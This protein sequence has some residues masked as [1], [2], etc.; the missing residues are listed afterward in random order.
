MTRSL[1][2][3]LALAALS[4][5]AARATSCSPVCECP[6]FVQGQGARD[7]I[8]F[9]V[10]GASDV[11]SN[12]RPFVALPGLDSAQI[13]LVETASG[14]PVPFTIEPSPW[15]ASHVWIV[16]DAMLSGGLEY[17]LTAGSGEGEVS[18][19]AVSSYADDRAPDLV[20]L[21][22]SSREPCNEVIFAD[23]SAYASDS[24]RPVLFHFIV[25]GPGLS[26]PAHFFRTSTGVF[27]GESG[28]LLGRSLDAEGCIEDTLPE[29]E[30]GAEYDVRLEAYDLA[31]QLGT[32]TPSLRITTQHKGV[33]P[34]AD[35]T[36][37]AGCCVL[38][39]GGRASY[40]LAPLA[41]LGIVAV[42]WRR[43][44]RRAAA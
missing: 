31:G 42:W 39:V 21:N 11:P 14:T 34:D 10:D 30:A 18:T 12:V 22:Q 6:L 33:S 27:S 32:E 2:L 29:A 44:R 26:S 17:T 43:R 24:A 7:S 9:P 3:L 37:V 19:F 38:S 28:L 8:L 5:S 13:T 20:Q 23:L 40:R 25:D 16:P 41:A 36:C 1:I 35:R 15:S 4:P